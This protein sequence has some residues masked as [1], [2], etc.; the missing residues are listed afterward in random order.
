MS[1]ASARATFADGLTLCG[2]YDGTVDVMRR[3]FYAS[4]DM[5][6]GAIE[7]RAEDHEAR[8]TCGGPPESV[9]VE[10]NYGT[11]S[12]DDWGGWESERCRTGMV[13]TG[14]VS[15]AERRRLDEPPEQGWW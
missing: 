8:C 11:S 15:Q 9:E 1:H 5:A 6:W 12:F 14:P 13:I 3:R 4:R 2:L 7:Q 10:T